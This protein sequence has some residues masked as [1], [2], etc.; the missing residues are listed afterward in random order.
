MGIQATTPFILKTLTPEGILAT[1]DKPVEW[2]AAALAF[3]PVEEQFKKY[4]FPPEGYPD[5]H[6]IWSET[7]CWTTCWNGGNALVRAFRNPKVEFYVVQ[8]ITLEDDA[9][10]ADLILPVTQHSKTT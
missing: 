7:P 5:I 9:L 6:M 8:R 2:Y 1:P 3:A 10:F 4:Q